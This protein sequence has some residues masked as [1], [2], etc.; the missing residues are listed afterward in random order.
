MK[1][2]LK[3]IVSNTYFYF[4]G[5]PKSVVNLLGNKKL[6]DPSGTYYPEL[7]HKS[8]CAIIWD[9]IRLIAKWHSP[10]QYYFLYGFDVK[11][12][13]EQESYLPYGL[14]MKRR[15]YL[16][17]RPNKKEQYSYTGILRDKFYFSIFMEKLGFNVPKT[18]GLFEHGNMYLL[19]ENKVLP[20]SLIKPGRYI[21]KPLDG[22][23]G[24]GIVS[25]DVTKEGEVLI[26]NSRVERDSELVER[27][28]GQRYFVQ[29]RIE[30]QH[31]HMA[32]LYGKSINTLRVTTVRNPKNGQIELIGC[33]L[34]M[35]ARGSV[36]SNWHY[37][38]V[39]INVKEDGTLDK[40]GYSL[41]DRRI[42]CHPETKVVFDSFKVPHYD[43]AVKEAMRCHEIFY[44][45]HS[46]GWDFAI[47]PEGVM[48][49][50]G[51]DNWGMAAH[52][53]VSG[54]LSDKFKKYFYAK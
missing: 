32:T 43:I 39:I 42:T 25:L 29:E 40:Y 12:R 54:G 36:V 4:L 28:K 48:F 7:K 34:L 18:L 47:L 24:V 20:L 53:M 21:C 26:D 52:Q 50:E 8:K 35:G 41:Y 30:E 15:D 14:F 13:K 9:Q 10:E 27:F 16:N 49:I 19:S 31:P 45:V 23:G 51:N 2:T 5:F 11:S 6:Y 22:I 33:M 37:G 44:G 3:R 38:G 46:I 17:N 1:K